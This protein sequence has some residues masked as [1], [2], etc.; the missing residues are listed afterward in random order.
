MRTFS[1][2]ASVALLLVSSLCLGACAGAGHP[3]GQPARSPIAATDPSPMTAALPPA[4][5]AIPFPVDRAAS[6][7]PDTVLGSDAEGESGGVDEGTSLLLDE[8]PAVK[9]G[10]AIY[11]DSP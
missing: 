6:A 8:Q 9:A 4:A 3:A 2:A 7:T 10:Y 11:R 1:A 5:G